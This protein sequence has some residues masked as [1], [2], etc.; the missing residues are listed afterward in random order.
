MDVTRHVNIEGHECPI[1]NMHAPSDDLDET[2]IT[3]T[4]LANKG[5]GCITSDYAQTFKSSKGIVLNK[6][7][8]NEE[9]PI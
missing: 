1:E 8:D 2:Q 5:G 4:W 9:R 3:N 6:A 7:R